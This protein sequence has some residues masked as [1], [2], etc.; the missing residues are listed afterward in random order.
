MRFLV[1]E[2]QAQL[3]AAVADVLAKEC[4]TRAVREAAEDARAMEPM[5]DHLDDMGLPLALVDES[6]GGLGLDAVD[7]VGCFEESGAHAVPIPIVETVAVAAPL[8]SELRRTDLL[9]RI[10]SGTTRY[11]A[12]LDDSGLVPW[13]GGADV[14]LSDQSAL[15]LVPTGQTQHWD[16]VDAVDRTRP[17]H[18]ARPPAASGVELLTDDRYLIGQAWLGGVVATAAQLVGVS[19]T[20]LRM[21]VEYAKHRHQFGVQIGSFQAVKHRLADALVLVEMARPVVFAGAWA[22]ARGMDS[23]ERDVAAAKAQASHCAVEVARI[24]L[25]V[26]GAIGY[27]SEYDLQIYMKRAW[28]LTSA[29]GHR[30][31]RQLPTCHQVPRY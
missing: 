9:E 17:L 3:R 19:T 11:T 21:A 6:M 24:A 10:E 18:R 16:A 22:L 2:Q 7:L 31:S 13:L 5:W 28:A 4:S 12:S 1:T 25:Q 15:W 14:L 23:R 26:H 27:T 30:L 8:F 29:S 20:M